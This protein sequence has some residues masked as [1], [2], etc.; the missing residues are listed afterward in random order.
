[1]SV[2]E[3]VA[4]QLGQIRQSSDETRG[5]GQ[6]LMAKAYCEQYD[7]MA[8]E[9]REHG[10]K[11]PTPQKINRRIRAVEGY[12]GPGSSFLSH[13]KR[14][15]EVFP[16]LFGAGTKKQYAQYCEI[17]VARLPD[18]VRA[19]LVARLEAGA[20]RAEIREA[21][22]SASDANRECDFKVQVSN[23]WRFGKNPL[24]ATF[25]GGIHPEL[26]ANLIHHFSDAGEHI[27]DPMAGGGTTRAVLEHYRWFQHEHP[28]WP[29]I[30]GARTVEMF[31]A[32]PTSRAIK[33]HDILGGE[34]PAKRKADLVVFDPPYWGIAEGKYASL[35]GD[36]DEW[37]ANMGKAFKAIVGALADG[38]RV[39]AV[40]DDFQ[41]AS[42]TEPLFF[43]L[44]KQ[45]EQC[46]LRLAQCVY[47][48]YPNYIVSM[49][50]AQM[51]RC[52]KSRVLVN[53][54]KTI[55]VFAIA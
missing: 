54:M 44:A 1:M 9:L 4:K 21:I 32:A 28:Q 18:D 26:V 51:H 3:Q 33:E 45:A 50:A 40:V 13:A 24:P 29:V 31:D 47:N 2:I 38:G 34:I 39:C 22:R 15:F 12:A 43:L 16:E 14:T 10:E 25:D 35:G 8:T 6:F 53:E 36:I 5:N 30:S 37:L 52:K 23:C 42:R 41:R 11:S 20:T 48:A 46:G 17:A 19:D 49:G 55:G 7:A 27:I